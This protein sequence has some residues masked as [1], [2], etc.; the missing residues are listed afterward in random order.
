MIL[1]MNRFRNLNLNIAGRSSYWRALF[2]VLWIN[3]KPGSDTEGLLDDPI[4][5][6]SLLPWLRLRASASLPCPTPWAW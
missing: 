6:A 5:I 4:S 3:H 2:A 1:L